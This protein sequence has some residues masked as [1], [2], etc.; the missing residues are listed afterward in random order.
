MVTSGAPLNRTEA[1]QLLTG[2][3]LLTIGQRVV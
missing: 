3:D 1:Q 2:A